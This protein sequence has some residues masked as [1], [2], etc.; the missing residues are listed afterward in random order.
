MGRLIEA[1]EREL[2]EIGVEVR[3]GHRVSRLAGSGP[4]EV[5]GPDG[6]VQADAVLLAVPGPAA[7]EMVRAVAPAGARALA[8][9]RYSASAVVVM[10]FAVEPRRPLDAAGFLVAP[11]HGLATAA[12]SFLSVKWPHLRPGLW[13]RAIVVHPSALAKPDEA[14]RAR[15]VREVSAVLGLRREPE[16]VWLARWPTALPVFEP[17]HRGRVADAVRALPPGVAVAGAMLGA[18]G[19]PDCARSGEEAARRLVHEGGS[20]V[21]RTGRG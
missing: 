7:A 15:V 2:A 17:G 4:F 20:M 11:G 18:V 13:M 1:L 16:V 10:R 9:I 12:C 14:L 5:G 6:V 19:I 3:T 21:R 8:A